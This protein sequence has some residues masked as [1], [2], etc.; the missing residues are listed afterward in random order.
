MKFPTWIQP[1]V[2]GAIV[3]AIATAIVGF[4][5]GGWVTAGTA[6]DMADSAAQEA[7]TKIVAS[8][9]VD[10]FAAAADAQNQFA[11]LKKMDSWDRG[12]F[13]KKG[14]WS[15][16]PG[17]SGNISGVADACAGDLAAL[18]K[19]PAPVAVHTVAATKKS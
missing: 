1:G 5:W 3:G 19:L 17:I 14:G 13:I 16:I 15:T 6:R 11:K 18:A 12:D 7:S 4:S 9:C 2:S 10:K 8:L